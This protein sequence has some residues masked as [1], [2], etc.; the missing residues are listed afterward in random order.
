MI[1]EIRETK[2]FSI[3][4][5]A[6]ACDIPITTLYDVETGRKGVLAKRAKKIAFFLGVPLDKLF[7][8]TYY[9][10]KIS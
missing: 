8:P 5:V 3:K 2:G 4:D 10:A 1:R 9:R 6:T 7:V